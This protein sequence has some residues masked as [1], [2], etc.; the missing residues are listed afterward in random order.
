MSRRMVKKTQAIAMAKFRY[1]SSMM[2][3]QQ[4]ID[5]FF[6]CCYTTHSLRNMQVIVGL[7]HPFPSWQIREP[8]G[9]LYCS[10]LRNSLP[11]S[12]WFSSSPECAPLDRWTVWRWNRSWSP[13]ASNK[14]LVKWYISNICCG[15]NIYFNRRCFICQAMQFAAKLEIETKF[16]TDFGIQ[17]I[18]QVSA[19]KG[20][21]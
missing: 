7:P 8:K 20:V 12:A 13:V 14:L 18:F 6:C 17:V 15:I 2:T 19:E 11:L 5:C 16:G 1:N 10:T 21:R 3:F 9:R 4:W